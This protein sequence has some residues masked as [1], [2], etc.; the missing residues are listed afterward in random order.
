MSFTNAFNSM[1]PRALLVLATVGV[2]YI[3]SFATDIDGYRFRYDFTSGTKKFYGS[4]AQPKDPLLNSSDAMDLAAQPVTGLRGENTAVHPLNTA[5][6]SVNSTT[7]YDVLNADWT[8]AMSVRPGSTQEGVLFSIGRKNAKSRKNIS[9]CSS[10]DST[11]LLIHENI[12]NG[13]GTTSRRSSID[14]EADMSRGFHTVVLAYR[15]PNS[16][17]EGT[18]DFYVDGIHKGSLETID[19]AFGGGFQFC[20]T[21]SGIVGDEKVT[22]GDLNVAFRDVRFYQSAFSAA[23]A[24]KYAALYPADTLRP[25]ASI[26]AHG[27]NYVDTGYKVNK[28]TRVATDFQYLEVPQQ[29]RIFGVEGVDGSWGCELYIN[30]HGEYASLFNNESIYD[31][32]AFQYMKA[33]FYR[34]FVAINRPSGKSSFWQHDKT[35][36][37]NLRGSGTDETVATVSLPLFARHRPSGMES[38]SKSMIYSVDIQEKDSQQEKYNLVHFFAPHYDETLGACF[39]DVITGELKGESML[40]PAPTTKL[41]YTQG[42]G[43]SADYKY[44]DGILYAKVYVSS[45]SA[46]QGVVAVFAGEESISPDP[47]GD[48]YYWVAYGTEL[49]LKATPESGWLFNG[50]YGDVR[51]IKSGTKDSDEIIVAIDKVA[52]FEARF[53]PIE[54]FHADDGGFTASGERS[55]AKTDDPNDVD[56]IV[57]ENGQGFEGTESPGAYMVNGS[58]TFTASTFSSGVFGGTAVGY[59]LE[60]WNRDLK[61][62]EFVSYREG[63]SFSYTNCVANGRMCLTWFWKQTGTVRRYD[64]DDYIQ[65]DRQENGLLAHFDG[66]LNAGV[67]AAHETSPDKW[68]N[69]VDGGVN[70]V[71]HGDAAFKGDAW[72]SDGNSC[73]T[74]SFENVLKAL[75]DKK[76]TLEMMI[77]HPDKQN[78]NEYWAFFG[79]GA[80]RNLSV[81]FRSNNSKNPLVQGL[82]YRATGWNSAAT[83]KNSN[84]NTTKWNTRQY[85]AVVCDGNTATAYYNGT[86]KLHSTTG[87]SNFT[88]A[89]SLIGIGGFPVTGTY[90]LYNGSEICAVRMTAQAMPLWQIEYNNSVQ[91]Q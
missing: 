8:L 50:W 82:Q 69:L 90:C 2:M 30:K 67:N 15:K 33:N 86:N 44:E 84:G 3:P 63:D 24:K 19:Y 74:N 58:H 10:S 75:K 66:I 53:T 72:V 6:S 42:L 54:I 60:R 40:D 18:V 43:S 7:F 21:V 29:A 48:G 38:F 1:L 51:T 27:E 56:F 85:I 28:S 32:S 46:E 65:Y 87:E 37:D 23:D 62:W 78:Q 89:P 64:V 39:K 55:A 41:S 16:S 70:L 13:S 35:D 91:Q 88:P 4:E 22:T 11:K 80:Q 36:T 9:I 76:F 47:N 52:Q 77:S 17:N 14:L 79:D 59:R 31:D 34:T 25:Y 20:T 12:R 57:T 83:I 49:T 68:V 61:K 26:K 5:W 81:D 45:S 73:F 71:K